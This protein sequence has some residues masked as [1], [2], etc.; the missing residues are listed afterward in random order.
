MEREEALRTAMENANIN[1]PNRPGTPP[2]Q[3]GPS[4][5]GSPT[6]P[7]PAGSGGLAL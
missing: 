7:Q 5:P 1:D 3:H 2:S 4:N 6:S